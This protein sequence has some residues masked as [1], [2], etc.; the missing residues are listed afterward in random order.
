MTLFGC[1]GRG[2]EVSIVI[3]KRIFKHVDFHLVV[4]LSDCDG[5]QYRDR[6]CVH[7][8]GWQKLTIWILVCALPR[9]TFMDQ[10]VH[11]SI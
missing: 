8:L 11:P 5:H 6:P 4:L 10:K 7:R 9:L 1:P 3:E 2:S